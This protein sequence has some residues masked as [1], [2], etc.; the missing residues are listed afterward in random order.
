MIGCSRRNTVHI[1]P[2]VL[3][4]PSGS[5]N[6]VQVPRA[7]AALTPGDI[8]WTRTYC[9]ERK[10]WAHW[11]NH[12][13]EVVKQEGKKRDKKVGYE[14]VLILRAAC[15]SGMNGVQCINADSLQSLLE[16]SGDNHQEPRAVWFRPPVCGQYSTTESSGQHHHHPSAWSK[17]QSSGPDPRQPSPSSGQDAAR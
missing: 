15:F 4:R 5:I 10:H 12:C 3:C 17:R 2:A 9:E 1:S 7:S 14:R 11:H 8:L 13:T 6:F 16:P